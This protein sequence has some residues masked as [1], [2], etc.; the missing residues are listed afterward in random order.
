MGQVNPHSEVAKA[1]RKGLLPKLDG[2]IKCVDCGKPAHNYEHRDY[3][4]PLDVSP[5]CRSCNHK[6]G[7]AKNKGNVYKYGVVTYLSLRE[8]TY[9]KLSRLAAKSNMRIS[10]IIPIIV[11]QAL[12]AKK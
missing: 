6:R 8:S 11:E 1:V 3:A 5:V 9:K 7:P 10:K 2:T 4:K 12:K